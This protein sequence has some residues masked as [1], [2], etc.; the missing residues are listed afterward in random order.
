MA[1]PAY[2]HVRLVSRAIQFVLSGLALAF[3]AASF[4]SFNTG[5]NHSSSYGSSAATFT[6]LMTSWSR[7][8]PTKRVIDGLLV[9]VLIAAGLVLATSDYADHCNELY[10]LAI[11][12]GNLKAGFVFTFLAA[13]ALLITLG[14][15]FVG[16]TTTLDSTQTQ[17]QVIVEPAPYHIDATPTGA[18]SPIGTANSPSRNV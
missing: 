11:K 12:C 17:E 9:V 3:T 6:I 16:A 13:A 10:F 15:N 2:T 1:A 7:S 4:R 5:F 18:L 14:L 8:R